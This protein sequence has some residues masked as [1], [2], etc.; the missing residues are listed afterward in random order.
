MAYDFLFPNTKP[1]ALRWEI[2]KRYNRDADIP[3][4]GP[5][6]DIRLKKRQH[7]SRKV[8]INKR[9]HCTGSTTHLQRGIEGNI[10]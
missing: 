4:I 9:V 10:Y 3:I 8:F 2:K 1:R 7:D 5:R 6:D